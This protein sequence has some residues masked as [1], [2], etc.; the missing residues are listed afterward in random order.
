MRDAGLG[1]QHLSQSSYRDV[2]WTVAQMITHH[3]VNGCNLQLGDLLGS[4]TQSG[5]EPEQAGSLLELGNGGKKAVI[6]TNGETRTFLE[7]GDSVTPRAH[8][9]RSG[10][11]RIGFGDC[12]GECWLQ[13]AKYRLHHA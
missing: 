10:Y 8:C 6:L 11:R 3:T 1:P 2:Y 12:Q 7:D 9:A 13:A 4:G 5:A